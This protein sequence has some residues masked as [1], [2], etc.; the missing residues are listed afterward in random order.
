MVPRVGT[1]NDKRASQRP[2][3]GEWLVNVADDVVT[4]MSTLEVIDALRKGRL[5]EESLVWRNG[6]HDWTTVVDVPQLRLA[7]GSRPPPVVAPASPAIAT[8]SAEL[9]DDSEEAEHVQDDELILEPAL[10]PIVSEAAPST[11]PGSLAPTTTETRAT[12]PTRAAGAWGDLDALLS[13]ER[14]AEQ[15]N[16]KRVVF[17]AALGAAAM[18][19]TF[20]LFV[21]RSH[22]RHEPQPAQ[23]DQ[24]NSAQE[25]APAPPLPAPAPSTEALPPASASAVSRAPGPPRSAPKWGAPRY[26]RRP[27]HASQVTPTGDTS[28]AAASATSAL[29]A[30]DTSTAP[31]VAVVPAAALE[32]APVSAPAAAPPSG[33]PH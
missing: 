14:S 28:A 10:T 19:A 25:L 3:H 32:P 5:S 31:S 33:E 30:P 20:T 12:D 27:K 1:E 22:A 13:S 11:T 15:Q 17:W 9:S 24:A 26:A 21:L 2:N 23:A 8:P 18:A 6:M 7:A 29:T 16:T 4:P